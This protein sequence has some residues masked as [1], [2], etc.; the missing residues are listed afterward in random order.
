MKLMLL[1]GGTSDKD[2]PSDKDLTASFTL[3]DAD[4]SGEAAAEGGRL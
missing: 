1:D 4:K 2:M 3:V